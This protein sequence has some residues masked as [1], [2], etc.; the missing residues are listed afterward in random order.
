MGSDLTV[1]LDAGAGSDASATGDDNAVEAESWW[2]YHLMMVVV[3]MFFAMLLSDWSIQPV[4]EPDVHPDY[5]T[6]MQSFWIKL[7][8]QWACLLM[9][10][11]TL[12]APYLLRDVRDF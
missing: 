1:T 7:I 10:A 9:Y 12:L 6:S 2:Y 8:A 3:S 5:R 11:W 4:S